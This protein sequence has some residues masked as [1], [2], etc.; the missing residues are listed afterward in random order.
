[1]ISLARNCQYNAAAYRVQFV[2]KDRNGRINWDLE[3]SDVQLVPPASL[4]PHMVLLQ[5]AYMHP[6]LRATTVSAKPLLHTCCE[7]GFFPFR[8]WNL[9]IW[10]VSYVLLWL[11]LHYHGHTMAG[12]FHLAPWLYNRV[13]IAF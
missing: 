4:K 6:T 8:V 12:T 3:R 11:D 2:A 10:S 9:W 13:R 1:M 5:R 7:E